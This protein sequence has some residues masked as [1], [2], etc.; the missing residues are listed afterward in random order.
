MF[1]K[2]GS[3]D[4]LAGLLVDADSQMLT[5]TSTFCMLRSD[6]V[7]KAEKQVE[8]M[9]G[10]LQK[11]HERMQQVREAEDTAFKAASSRGDVMIKV[12]SLRLLQF[13]VEVFTLTCASL[14]C[15]GSC[16]A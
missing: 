10:K 11:L 13:R 6:E 14:V 12:S 8:V 5:R 16:L 3:C 15:T 7:S 4:T 2:A 9:F 1:V